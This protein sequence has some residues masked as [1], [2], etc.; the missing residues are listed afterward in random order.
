L[1]HATVFVGRLLPMIERARRYLAAVPP[2]IQGQR[3]DERTF[4]ICCTLVR[5]FG[6]TDEEAL[7]VLSEW[8]GCCQPPWTDRALADKVRRSR[9]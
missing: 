6:L 3:G 4:R 7:I 5:R 2:A 8:N 1:L 9:G